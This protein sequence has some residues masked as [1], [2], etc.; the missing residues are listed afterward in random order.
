VLGEKLRRQIAGGIYDDTEAHAALLPGPIAL[1]LL[2]C[3]ASHN[4]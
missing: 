2:I 4:T 1:L 3:E